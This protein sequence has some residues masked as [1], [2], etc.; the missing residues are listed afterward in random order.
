MVLTDVNNGLNNDSTL[1]QSFPDL[2]FLREMLIESF[3]NA[4][5]KCFE[6]PNEADSRKVHR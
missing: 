1:I 3:V 4:A 6:C 2:P 5:L